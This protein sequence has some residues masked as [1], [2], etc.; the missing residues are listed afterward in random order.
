ML[1]FNPWVLI[2]LQKKESSDLDSGGTLPGLCRI[3]TLPT[4]FPVILV[5]I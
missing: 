5:E 4:Y 1:N 3:V 2:V